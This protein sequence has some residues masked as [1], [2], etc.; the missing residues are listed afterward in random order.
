MN[1]KK[2]ERLT[3]KMKELLEEGFVGDS[4][5]DFSNLRKMS[6]SELLML[7]S[8]DPALQTMMFNQECID[9]CISE[10][11]L[12]MNYCISVLEDRQGRTKM[13]LEETREDVKAIINEMDLNRFIT[14]VLYARKNEI[15]PSCEEY[16]DNTE[17]SLHHISTTLMSQKL[18]RMLKMPKEDQEAIATGML[19]HDSGKY[20]LPWEIVNKKG[21]LADKEWEIMKLHPEIGSLIIQ[22]SGYRIPQK[23]MDIILMHHEK[24]DG[25][26]YPYGLTNIPEHVAVATAV[27]MFDALIESRPYRRKQFGV[28][29]AID[30]LRKSAEQGLLEKKV[31]DCLVTANREDRSLPSVTGYCTTGGK[32]YMT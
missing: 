6:R 28:H 14:P 22:K 3:G 29:E 30:I 12:F 17:T 8:R 20:I 15:M 2:T 19:L 10:K 24:K 25:S 4:N 13:F 26:G 11:F 9:Q 27:D 5:F 1:N 31:V 32:I 23:S 16:R 7:F 21:Q 18:A